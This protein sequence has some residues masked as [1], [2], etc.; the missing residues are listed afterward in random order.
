MTLGRWRAGNFE[1]DSLNQDGVFSTLYGQEWGTTATGGGHSLI[2]GTDRL[3]GWNP[4][5]YDVY[6]PK[7]NFSTLVDSVKKYNGFIYLAHP[8]TDQFGGIFTGAYNA[9]Y[10]SV[11]QGVALKNG[12]AFSTSTTESDPSSTTYESRYHDLLKK[13]YHVA[14]IANQDNHNTTFGR[15]N[16]QRTVVL[17]ESLTRANIV[18]AL[19]NRRVYATEDRNLQLQ[20]EVGTHRMGEIF[21]S[22]DTIRF[23][24]KITDPG[25]TISTIE[26][27]YGVPGSGNAP[28]VLTSAANKD[29][30]IYSFV[31][32]ENTTYYY[33]VYV[34]EADGHKAWSAPM[35][36]TQTASAVPGSFSLLSPSTGASDQPISGTL[37]WQ[38][39]SNATQYDVYLDTNNPPTTIVS[40]NQVSTSYSYSGLANSTVYYWKVVAKNGNGQTTSSGSPWSFT[41]IIA[42]PGSFVQLSPSNVSTDQPV[43]GTLTWQT[44]PNATQYDVYLDTA[45]PPTTIVSAN[46]ASTSYGYSGLMNTTTYYWKIVAKNGNGQ[47]T[48]SGSPWSFTTIVASPGSFDLLSP[49]NNATNQ[50][51]NGTLLWQ[52]SPNATQYDV[53]LDSINP[54][55]TV[56]S[57]NQETTSYSYS[58]L[59]NGTTYYW[60]VV[61]KNVGGQTTNAG[62]PWNFTTSSTPPPL[63]VSGL[64]INTKTS[65]SVILEWT[66]NA[67]NE[68]GYRVYRSL[69]S[70]GPFV[71]LGSDLPANTESFSDMTVSPN[72]RYYYRIVAY[73]DGG[74]SSPESI[75]VVSLAEIP[76]QPVLL[77]LGTSSIK[78]ILE[79]ATNSSATQFSIRIS[80]D[81]VANFVQHDGT[82]GGEPTWK[83]YDEWGGPD[84]VIINGLQN[85]TQYSVSVSARN[86]DSLETA[87]SLSEVESTACS[88]SVS[89]LMQEGWNLVSLPVMP[90][91]NLR[92][93]LFPQSVSNA[94]YYNEGYSVSD[95]LQNGR[96]YWLKFPA[97]ELLTFDGQWL[98]SDTIIVRQGWNI[99]GSIS[100]PV[101]VNAILEE[102]TGVIVT[103]YYGYG[104][105][106]FV[107]DTIQPSKGYW[108]KA[109]SDGLL[110][111]SSLT[112][113][114]QKSVPSV[115]PSESN[116]TVKFT[117]GR[118]NTQMLYLIAH[119]E[120]TQN[121]QQY[122]LP[123]VP[124]AGA[125][126]V[127][128]VSQRSVELLNKNTR[129]EFPITIQSSGTPV[130]VSLLANDK[131]FKVK[132]FDRRKTIPLSQ[133][134]NVM[135]SEQQAAITLIVEPY[136]NTVTPEQ[137]AL[138]QNYPN[139][140]NPS[141]EISYQLPMESIVRLTVYN[142]L[143]ETVAS[144]VNE[145]QASG[146]HSVVWQPNVP[147]GMYYY[148]MDAV[149]AQNPSETF[150]QV[151]RMVLLK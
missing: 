48:S 4:G 33:Y 52:A 137:F 105:S 143:G 2:Y 146:V 134:A 92:E 57:A 125:F 54:P 104:T 107:T 151:R 7:N 3:F 19:R 93:V 12:P 84:G 56:V 41:T 63:P 67:T 37:S 66:D 69:A 74:E 97:D 99:I 145:K 28:T 42:A 136:N 113:A 13:G 61:A 75:V 135:L 1:A 138:Y 5:V 72:R 115:S 101:P 10:D 46:Q 85:C 128:F 123:P 25:E 127:R 126:D 20:F 26:L 44:S 21:S 96:G 15:A 110:I 76:G 50:P 32:A 34:L 17:A 64:S 147:S 148:R 83:R 124:P 140:F 119:E 116:I 55:V 31:Q 49:S 29:S 120:R 51:V 73:N 22:S 60:K 86:D 117:D 111:L 94:Y 100:Q 90:T 112:L 9:A 6:V 71:Q 30:L 149:N 62:S 70:E 139:P 79:P 40:A 45:N 91:S 80:D 88:L 77:S 81:S 35:W 133:G 121:Y 16:Q 58:G 36:I 129:M 23:R 142:L 47:T 103:N 53:Y 98:Y 150:Q 130:T 78:C 27:R 131:S 141:T 43:N 11:V 89:S 82:R 108:V 132:I 118:G 39:S 18:D 106:Y 87:F 144:L 59:T 109:N 95:S 65:S 14:P 114:Q 102:P 122:E 38:T 24:I 68:V 8:S